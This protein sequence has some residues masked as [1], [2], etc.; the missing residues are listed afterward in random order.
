MASPCDCFNSRVIYVLIVYILQNP[1]P[2]Q[3]DL[4]KNEFT[5]ARFFLSFLAIFLS[6]SSLLGVLFD[7]VISSDDNISLLK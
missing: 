7:C 3:N 4:C 5:C 1:S 2:L 6:F